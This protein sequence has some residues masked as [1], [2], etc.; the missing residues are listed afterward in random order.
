MRLKTASSATGTNEDA[1]NA[2]TALESRLKV[3]VKIVVNIAKLAMR[4]M[5]AKFAKQALCQLKGSAT[6]VQIAAIFA[7]KLA[8]PSVTTVFRAS[9]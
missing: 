9:T 2:S 8:Q 1:P 6:V 7:A 5:T 3:Y 4:S